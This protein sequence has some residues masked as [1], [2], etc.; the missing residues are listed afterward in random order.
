[1]EGGRRNVDSDKWHGGLKEKEGRLGLRGGSIW[2]F[3]VEL[4]E[5][6]ERMDW[7]S[8]ETGERDLPDGLESQLKEERQFL[9]KRG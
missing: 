5:T 2:S 9:K 6:C 3:W 1:M 4:K 7:R 8:Q